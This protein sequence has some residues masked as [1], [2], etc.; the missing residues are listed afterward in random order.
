MPPEPDIK[1]SDES[2]LK[3]SHVKKDNL[4]EK[5]ENADK[6]G[7][8]SHTEET[9]KTEQPVPVAE[10]TKKEVEEK[11]SRL[12][13]ANQEYQEGS[14]P[15]SIYLGSF[16][17][18][19]RAERAVEQY[20]G[21]D[22]YSYPVKINFTK[23]GIWYRVY[24]GYFPDAESAGV[25]VEENKIQDAE[26]KKTAYAC[27]IDSFTDNESLE[28]YMR[29]L[30]EKQFF[31]YVITDHIDNVHFLFSGA[32]ITR[33]AAEELSEELHAAGINNSVVSR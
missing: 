5:N 20:A 29:L 25:F 31:P 26:I 21:K 3:T 10:E 2:S 16:K 12:K 17:T 22:I 28:N 1:K 33:K 19:E 24:S 4:P 14:Y 27:C 15:Y 11:E 18:V 6:S 8:P 30:R 13:E 9:K 23:K 32:F 7:A